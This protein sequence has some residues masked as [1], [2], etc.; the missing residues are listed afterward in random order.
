[1]AKFIVIA[2][3]L[4]AFIRLYS[5]I[6]SAAANDWSDLGIASLLSSTATAVVILSM[7]IFVKAADKY[8]NNKEKD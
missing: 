8:I 6:V 4:A 5:G 7:T 1:M 3:Y 2:L